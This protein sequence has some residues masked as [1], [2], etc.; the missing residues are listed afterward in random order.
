MI[1][2][3][4]NLLS[5]TYANTLEIEDI[6]NCSLKLI[7]QYGCE[8]TF[9]TKTT[10]GKTQIFKYGPI[11]SDIELF[12][13]EV[14]CSFRRIDFNVFALKKELLKFICKSTKDPIIDIY[15]IPAEDALNSCRS[16]IDYVKNFD[17]EKRY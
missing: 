14:E 17:A 2:I 10:L 1:E 12:P 9:I 15:E 13:A 3:P 4:Y 11:I 16:I 8:Y 7:S 6:G 5:K